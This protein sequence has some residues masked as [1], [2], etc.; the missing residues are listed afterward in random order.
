MCKIMEDLI[1]N[2]K[3]DSAIRLLPHAGTID[4]LIQIQVT[5]R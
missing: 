3:K 2:E 1:D 4:V 5:P